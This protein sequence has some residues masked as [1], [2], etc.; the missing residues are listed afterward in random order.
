MLDIEQ[1]F[2]E[3]VSNLF[4][5]ITKLFYK[6]CNINTVFSRIPATRAKFTLMQ[7][8]AIDS[9][10]T[11]NNCSLSDTHLLSLENI[12]RGFYYYLVGTNTSFKYQ[13]KLLKYKFSLDTN[14]NGVSFWS[15]NCTTYTKG[16]IILYIPILTDQNI[17]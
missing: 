7:P 15:N 5:K 16:I 10:L 4:L 6:L 9:L 17:Y 11:T 1:R 12:Y 2:N 13:V 8:H 3:V 14:F